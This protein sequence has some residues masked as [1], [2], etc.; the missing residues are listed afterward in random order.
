[1]LDIAVPPDRIHLEDVEIGKPVN[2][3][4]LTVT[5]DDIIAYAKAF[6]PQPIHLDEEAAKK[7]IV[8]GLCASG[9]HSCALLMRI[10]A[11]DYLRNATSL[12]SPGI[13]EVKWMRP[14]RPGDTLTGRLVATEKRVLASRP[15]VG[16]AKLVIEMLNQK[17]ETVM[18]WDSNQLLAVRHPGAAQT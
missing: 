2:F 8:G 17:A 7:S 12:G 15:G 18:R 13:D 4:P 16:I 11:D 1:M 9:F 10:L 6:D 3:G 5:K 14:V